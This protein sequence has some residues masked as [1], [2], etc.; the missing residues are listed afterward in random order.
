MIVVQRF[1]NLTI[2]TPMHFVCINANVFLLCCADLGEELICSSNNTLCVLLGLIIIIRTLRR[3]INQIRER[4]LLFYDSFSKGLVNLKINIYDYYHICKM[5]A[6]DGIRK[7]RWYIKPFSQLKRLNT[8]TRIRKQN[9]M[10]GLICTALYGIGMI[11]IALSYSKQ[12][13]LNIIE[14]KKEN[15]QIFVNIF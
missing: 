2:P 12:T 8:H 11:S 5:V 15:K 4:I 3:W 10:M 9:L 14:P 7:V 6:A 1:L 13:N